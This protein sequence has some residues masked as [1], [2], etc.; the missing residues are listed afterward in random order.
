MSKRPGP[1]PAPR[2]SPAPN[3]T[4]AYLHSRQEESVS[5]PADHRLTESTPPGCEDVGKMPVRS[6]SVALLLIG[7]GAAGQAQ[8]QLR[9]PP[10]TISPC[11]RVHSASLLRR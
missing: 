7:A 11:P 6:L 5:P 9:I 1:S 3:D 10:V 8:N 2:R 4:A